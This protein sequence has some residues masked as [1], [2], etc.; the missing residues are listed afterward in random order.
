MLAEEVF[1][2]AREAPFGSQNLADFGPSQIRGN[3]RVDQL[4]QP[5][6]TGKAADGRFLVA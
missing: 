3:R 2:A 5:Y 6:R 4:L 1:K